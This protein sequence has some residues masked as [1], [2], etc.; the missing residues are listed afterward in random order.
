MP[1]IAPV[2]VLKFKPVGR[3]GLMEKVIPVPSVMVGI[4]G[5]MSDFSLITKGDAYEKAALLSSII[6][7]LNILVDGV[8]PVM[9]YSTKPCVDDGVPDNAPVVGSRLKPAGSAGEIVWPELD[10]AGNT[11]EFALP[12]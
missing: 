6:L 11:A 2:A 4:M 1:V 9:V 12:T 8:P 3:L 10:P 5:V 7:N